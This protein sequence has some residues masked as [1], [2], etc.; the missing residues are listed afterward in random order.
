MREPFGG[1]IDGPVGA[2]AISPQFQAATPPR[3]GGN[4]RAHTAAPAPHNP[5]FGQRRL[6]NAMQRSPASSDPQLALPATP[7]TSSRRMQ[8]RNPWRCPVTILLADGAERRGTTV[9]L[10]GEGLSLSTDRPIAPGSRCVLR[11][12]VVDQPREVRVDAK[13]VYSSYTAPGDF[14]IGMVLAGYDAQQREQLRALAGLA[15][16]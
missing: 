7:G 3:Q 12:Q 2:S 11:L 13:A 6:S 5:A 1:V 10:S 15:A 14:R 16:R 8:P 9:D 4:P